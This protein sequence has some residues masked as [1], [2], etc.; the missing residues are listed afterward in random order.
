MR[1]TPAVESRPRWREMDLVMD[2]MSD[3]LSAVRLDGA[4]YV[5]AEFTAPWCVATQFGLHTAAPKL[6][7]ADHVLFFHLLTDGSCFARLADGG[8]VFEVKAGDLLLL[9][10]DD[11]HVLVSDLRLPF[12][13]VRSP[14]PESGGLLEL[15]AGAGGEPTRFICGYLACD[16]RASRALL[17]SLPPILRIS[18]GDISRSGWLADLLRV[19][20][21]ESRAQRPGSQSLLA[22][23]S[24]LAFT[25]GLRRYAQSNPPELKGGLAGLQDPYVGRALALLHGEPTRGWTV[26]H[27]ARE[28]ALSRSALAERFGATIGLPPMQYL[29]QWR[30]TLAAQTL[31]AGTESIARIAERSGYDSEAAFTRAF[32]RE[33]GVPPTV[34]RRTDA[35]GPAVA[36]AGRAASD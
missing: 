4:V 8:E 2:A 14:P 5:D 11:L 26:D 29:T 27:L 36:S 21:A 18:L 20:V 24:E 25:E 35:S 32:K 33:F 10:H 1:A 17:G 13:A 9:P 6:P 34:W 12:A 31:R 3:V 19:G 15:R 7:E 28:V 22:K 16:R 23:L 30:L